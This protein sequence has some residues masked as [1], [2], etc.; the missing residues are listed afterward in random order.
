MFV[1]EIIITS[2]SCLSLCSFKNYIHK[3]MGLWITDHLSHFYQVPSKYCSVMHLRYYPIVLTQWSSTYVQLITAARM[4]EYCLLWQSGTTDT[5]F[6]HVHLRL[7]LSISSHWT[8]ILILLLSWQLRSTLASSYY[9]LPFQRIF[10]FWYFLS[11]PP[12]MCICHMSR[13]VVL[14]ICPWSSFPI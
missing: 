5:T 8:L 2:Y 13:S 7:P 12:G 10:L 3:W 1:W 14:G 4:A 6:S 11:R 9:V